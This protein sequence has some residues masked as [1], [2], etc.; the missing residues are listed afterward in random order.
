MNDARAAKAA[1]HSPRRGGRSTRRTST[2]HGESSRRPC[3][4]VCREGVSR[5]RTPRRQSAMGGVRFAQPR[6]LFARHMPKVATVSLRRRRGA[7]CDRDRITARAFA[8]ARR[9]PRRRTDAGDDADADGEPSSADLVRLFHDRC[10]V[11]IDSSG[12]LLHRR[13]YR[14]AVAKAPMRETLA[15]ATLMASGWRGDSAVARPDV[16][17]GHHFDRR[18][19][20]RA[21]DRAGACTADFA[22]EQWPDFDAA[23]WREV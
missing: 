2:S 11:S 13:G 9:D 3:W 23:T 6:R 10:T 14:Q 20:D 12:A 17:I 18:R 4:R 1:R 15:A 21:A 8:G 22:F 5:A 7:C 19:A 16:R